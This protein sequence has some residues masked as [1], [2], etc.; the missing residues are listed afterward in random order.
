MMRLSRA[1]I[2]WTTTLAFAL[3]VLPLPLFLGVIRPAFAVI[4]VVFWSLAAPRPLGIALGFFTG[5]ALDVY[6]GVT[7]GQHAL[8]ASLVAYVAIRQHLIVRNKTTFEQTIFCGAMLLL[9]ELT[10]WSIEALT[11]S[12][13][14]HWTRWVPIASGTLVWTLLGERLA[15]V[16]RAQR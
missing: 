12:G 2:V 14:A 10:V 3:Q 9:F 15:L 13:S 7:L 4:A 8:A 5:L 11:G 1:R 16:T 6:Q